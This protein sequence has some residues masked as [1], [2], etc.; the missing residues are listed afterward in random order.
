MSQNSLLT[1]KL[2]MSLTSFLIH[3]NF[4][5]IDCSLNFNKLLNKQ[6]SLLICFRIWIY[7]EFQEISE[8]KIPVF[9]DDPILNL[10]RCVFYKY[11]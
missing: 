10:S 7:L 2:N 11:S 8:N 3:F 9:H 1:L 4:L 6:N 5:Q